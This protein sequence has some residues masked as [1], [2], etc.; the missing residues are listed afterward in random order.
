MSA[1][2]VGAES[3]LGRVVSVRRKTALCRRWSAVWPVSWDC[4]EI[5]GLMNLFRKTSAGREQYGLSLNNEMFVSPR[6]VHIMCCFSSCHIKIPT[7]LFWQYQKK[8]KREKA[9]HQAGL[10]V[11]V[12]ESKESSI[13]W[14]PVITSLC[15]W[16][17]HFKS[18]LLL[19]FHFLSVCCCSRFAVLL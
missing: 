2:T 15:S 5:G 6:T 17:I 9:D 18:E 19:L 10:Y 12:W 8:K 13:T 14:H 1:M 3:T 4:N 16:T 7:Y 11:L